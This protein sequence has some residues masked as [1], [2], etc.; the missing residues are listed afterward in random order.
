MEESMNI[1]NKSI[2]T[3]WKKYKLEE[4]A[5]VLIGGTPSRNKPEFWDIKKETKNIWI[6]IR[7][8]SHNGKY[9]SDSSEYLSDEGVRNSNVKLI[10][11]NTLLMSFKLSIGKVAITKTDIYT[12]EAI[13]AFK[14]K[15]DNLV[16]YNY[17]Y[18]TLPLLAYNT[19][20]AIKGVTLN[21]EKLKE[22]Q[23]LFPPKNEQNKIAEILSGVDDEIEKV[24]EV[25][26][27]M[28]EM[29]NGLMTELFTKGIG[30]I[31]FKKTKLGEIP[32]EWEVLR[33]EEVASVERGKFSHRPRNAPQ[34]YNGRYPFI[35][36]SDVVNSNG[37]IQ[38]YQQTLNDEGLK[39]SRM[40][41]K[42][43]IVVTIAA[44]IGDTGILYFD[45]CFPDSLVG[46]IVKKE[47]DNVFL[48]YFLRTR[49]DYL[50]SISSQ[51]AQKNINLEKLR[52]LLIVKPSLNEQK[53]IAKILFEVD[54]KIII[55]KKTKNKLTELK[56]GLMQDLLSGIVRV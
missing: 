6:S 52:P 11:R 45:S 38:S 51:S 37:K 55:N 50:N 24:E 39:I 31:K 49:K 23:I 16:G 7:D 56:N 35:Q 17:L 53:Q 21:K 22:A 14:I 12:N 26:K 36:T 54:N 47:V 20:Q 41:S 8:L 33:L 25:I 5:D 48:E 27:K 34:F 1:N 29:K 40:F 3:D 15:D 2:P 18:Y 28:E 32:E 43:T 9:I 44:N 13:A 46:I 19:D 10:P 30:H 4:I 42:G